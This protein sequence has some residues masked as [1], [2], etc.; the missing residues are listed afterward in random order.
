MGSCLAL[1]VYDIS[2][3]DHFKNICLKRKQVSLR[4]P[5]HLG[6]SLTLDVIERSLVE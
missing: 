2:T 6:A 3:P 5:L 1:Q 4:L